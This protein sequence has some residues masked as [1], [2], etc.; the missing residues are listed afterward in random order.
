MKSLILQRKFFVI[1]LITL[2]V[3]FILNTFFKF[4]G[5]GQ[6]PLVI[7]DPEVEY[8]LKPNMAYK[9]FGNDIKINRYSMRSADFE[10]DNQQ[11]FYAIIGDSVV[12]GEHT[13]DQT[14][15]LAFIANYKLKEKFQDESIVVGSIAASSWGPENM[16]AFYEKFGPFKGETAFLVLSS[17]DRLDIPYMTRKLTPYRLKEPSFP[18]FDFIQ[19]AFERIDSR[20]RG[21]LKEV[22]FK[23]RLAQ[24]EAG[25]NN[26]ISLLKRDYSKVVLIFHATRKEALSGS[27]RGE[28]YYRKIAKNHNI[29]LFSTMELYKELYSMGIEPH[30]DNIHMTW[31]GNQWLSEKFMELA[32]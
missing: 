18:L 8:Y 14:E 7:L 27:S 19:S 21:D 10:R 4:L 6:A 22:S 20:I 16:A 12:Y 30:S 17:H 25:L 3:T 2:A 24:S 1:L 15:T 32:N 13:L 11:P 9:R 29:K 5:F 31:Q 26:L 23:K 28:P